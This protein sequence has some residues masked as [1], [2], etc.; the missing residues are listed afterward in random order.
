MLKRKLLLIL[1]AIALSALAFTTTVKAVPSVAIYG[2]VDKTQYM[3]GDTGTL[4]LWVVNDGTEPVILQTVTIEYPWHAYYI[5]EGNETMKNIDTAIVAGGNW[6]TSRTFTVPTD[7]RAKGGY[8][9]VHVVTDK[10]SATESFLITISVASPETTGSLHDL[11]QIVTLF[12]VTAVLLIV[13]TI[14]IAATL[15]LS[16]RKP[17]VT[18]KAE[19]KTQ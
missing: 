6:T 16:G 14:I 5:W 17:S 19:E 15:F 1:T 11:D 18:W 7:G 13:C 10:T 8:V 3:S 2:Y 12:T 4:K 9:Y